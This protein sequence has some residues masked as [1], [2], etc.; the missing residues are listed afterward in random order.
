MK[1][2]WKTT[3]SS[4]SSN[5]LVDKRRHWEARVEMDIL[6]IPDLGAYEKLIYVAL[7]G[8]ADRNGTA[9]PT[10]QTLAEMAS[11]SK[12]QVFRALVV[13]ENCRLVVRIPQIIAGRGQFASI[14]EVHDFEDCVFAAAETPREQDGDVDENHENTAASREGAADSREGVTDSHRGIIGAHEGVTDSHGDRGGVTDGHGGATDSHGGSVCQSHP[15]CLTGTHN[16]SKYNSSKVTKS[17]TSFGGGESPEAD[18][19]HTPPFGRREAGASAEN[20]E[21]ESGPKTENPAI[22]YRMRQPAE[23]FLLKT[24]RVRITESE[25][26]ALRELDKIHTASRVSREIDVAVKDF[27][28]QNR[29]LQSLSLNY[30]FAK[31][32]SQRSLPS[33]ASKERRSTDPVPGDEIS[34][35]NLSNYRVDNVAGMFMSGIIE[36]EEELGE[37]CD[38]YHLSEEEKS[39]VFRS[40]R[41]AA[42]EAEAE[43]EAEA[44]AEE[45]PECAAGGS[46]D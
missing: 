43:V 5:R 40:V 6:R 12:R 20:A 4:G 42:E 45:S 46:G 21:A 17:N 44:E 34:S 10:V 29:S 8:Y 1:N 32:R 41:D 7:C 3:S 9:F 24:G 30:V 2:D 19:P 35:Q 27:T 23:Y 28:R 15:P 36:T 22:P 13:L 25:A 11:C 39:R 26:E 37:V 38:L 31:L 16:N 14:Y 18:S 33:S